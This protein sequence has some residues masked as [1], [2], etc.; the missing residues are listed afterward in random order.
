MVLI[1][2]ELIS[3]ED[4]PEHDAESCVR[5]Q[6]DPSY[7]GQWAEAI[8]GRLRIQHVNPEWRDV[9]IV[10]WR[11]DF[12]IEGERW[13]FLKHAN[14]LYDR[15]Q[16]HWYYMDLIKGPGHGAIVGDTQW[17]MAGQ[18]SPAHAAVRVTTVDGVVSPFEQ[19]KYWI[20]PHG[21]V[22]LE[23]DR[24]WRRKLAYLVVHTYLQHFPDRLY[25]PVTNAANGK[26][27]TVHLIPEQRDVPEVTRAAH[28][29]G[30]RPPPA[31]S[32]WT[33]EWWTSSQQEPSSGGHHRNF[34]IQTPEEASQNLQGLPPPAE[35][36]APENS[37]H[38][39]W[40]R[41]TRW[42][43]QAAAPH[44]QHVHRQIALQQCHRS[45]VVRR[46]NKDRTLVMSGH[47]PTSQQ[48]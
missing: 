24:V 14:G 4:V 19:W 3:K 29:P 43:P 33:E 18:M 44:S 30:N 20:L 15:W 1:G 25:R 39:S 12:A 10:L 46:C 16:T 47:Q 17:M 31:N 21:I 45:Q 8:S 38:E 41:H 6:R 7:R 35:W 42:E 11:W 13:T 37:A 34:A 26:P 40:T 9:N 23:T 27:G 32:G 48:Q 2:W 36:N 28:A 22:L 5:H